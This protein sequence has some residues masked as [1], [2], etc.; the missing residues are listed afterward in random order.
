M[1]Y[2]DV[3]AHARQQELEREL[4]EIGRLTGPRLDRPDRHSPRRPRLIRWAR[5]ALD[6]RAVTATGAAS[7]LPRVTIRPADQNDAPRIATLAELDERRAPAGNALVAEVD[8]TIVAV[9]PLDGGPVM[10][11]PWRNTHDAVE[12]LGVR[13]GQIRKAQKQAA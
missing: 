8:D 12:L 6:G 13:S 4:E 5:A 2:A 9:M 1:Q 11:N 10:S 3:R 7:S